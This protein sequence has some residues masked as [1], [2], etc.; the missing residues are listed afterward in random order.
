MTT[1]RVFKVRCQKTVFSSFEIN[2]ASDAQNFSKSQLLCKVFPLQT[3][4]FLESI[5]SELLYCCENALK[6]ATD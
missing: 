1:A 4:I 3:A 2:R 5:V 6:N